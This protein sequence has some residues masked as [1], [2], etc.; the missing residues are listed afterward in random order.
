MS[1]TGKSR[2]LESRLMVAWC[3]KLGWSRN[4][5]ISMRFLSWGNEHVLN[6]IM[7]MTEPLREY[8][9]KYSIV[10]FKGVNFLVQEF[11][12]NQIVKINLSD[13][14]VT[15]VKWS[16]VSHGRLFATPW[17]VA[18]QAPPSM[19]FSTQEYWSGLPFLSPGDLPD[20]GIEPGSP[21]S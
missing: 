4:E 7:V 20:P 17:T 9:E 11:Y 13:R 3:L 1:R 5:V 2:W 16:E 12:L 18:H 19:G 21:T 14:I 6:L 10:Y 15:K 8:N